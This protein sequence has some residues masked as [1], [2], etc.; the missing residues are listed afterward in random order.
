MRNMA[1]YSHEDVMA[2]LK[3]VPGV[4]EH[5]EKPSIIM[6]R[7][8]VKR[9]QELNMTQAELVANG[10]KKGIILTQALISRAESGHEGITQGSI[11]K[12]VQVLGG[13]DDMNVSFK[14]PKRELITK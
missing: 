4:T 10:R 6:G 9:R 3:S 14:N 2:H 13:I 5:I 1:K 7:K 11:N 8:L 12:I